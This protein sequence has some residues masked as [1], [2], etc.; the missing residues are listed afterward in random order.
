MRFSKR[1]L[2]LFLVLFYCLIFL[3]QGEPKANRLAV[4]S[5][6]T[7][8]NGRVGCGMEVVECRQGNE[9]PEDQSVFENEDYIYSNSLP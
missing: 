7:S 1:S 6:G 2:F 3:V 8:A 4:G 5:A 9:G